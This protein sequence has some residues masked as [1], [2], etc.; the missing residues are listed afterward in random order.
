VAYEFVLGAQQVNAFR[1][2]NIADF[3]FARDMDA[4]N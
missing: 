2:G 4:P 1:F 3:F